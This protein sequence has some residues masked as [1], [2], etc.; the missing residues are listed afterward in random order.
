VIDLGWNFV[1][2]GSHG[3]RA[4]KAKLNEKSATVTT[5]AQD[6][7]SVLQFIFREQMDRISAFTLTF[8]GK[9]AE[10]TERFGLFYKYPLL[11]GYELRGAA[12]VNSFCEDDA[13]WFTPSTE[14]GSFDYCIKA[15]AD[16]RL[17]VVYENGVEIGQ[18]KY[19][20]EQGSAL[21]FLLKNGEV[22]FDHIKLVKG[23]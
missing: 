13:M 5:S 19:S 18:Y 20:K 3:Y 11:K 15:D 8:S 7:Y 22:T 1:T 16:S 17:A 4:S 2:G 12:H 14:D 9:L 23:V 21:Y 6:A 10:G